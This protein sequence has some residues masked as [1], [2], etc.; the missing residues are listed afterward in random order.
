MRERRRWKEEK[1]W[2]FIISIGGQNQTHGI[3]VEEVE[4]FRVLQSGGINVSGGVSKDM[5]I[6]VLL[7]TRSN[8]EIMRK[9]FGE[10]QSVVKW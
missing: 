3:R 4:R 8:D 9:S 7:E 10:W 6:H 2:V 5:H 1:G